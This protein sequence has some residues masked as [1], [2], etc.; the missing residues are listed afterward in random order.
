[1]DHSKSM[2]LMIRDWAVKF[3]KKIFL[4]RDHFF[5]G[6]SN[7]TWHVHCQI[8]CQFFD[9]KTLM[10]GKS[11]P[12]TVLAK[13]HTKNYVLVISTPCK[14]CKMAKKILLLQALMR[15][16]IGKFTFA[17]MR[18]NDLTRCLWVSG[19]TLKGKKCKKWNWQKL[20]EKHKITQI[21]T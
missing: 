16:S 9:G 5:T 10:D 20:H 15:D 8:S 2:K 11:L 3:W 18:Q 6:E 14:F 12:L 21:Q 13:I 19:S 17:R 1:M 4:K 7:E